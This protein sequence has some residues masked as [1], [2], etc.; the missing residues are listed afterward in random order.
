MENVIGAGADQE[1]GV[2]VFSAGV[3]ETEVEEAGNACA[4]ISAVSAGGVIPEEAECFCESL[5]AR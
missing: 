4:A 1:A 2:V 5:L 3:D